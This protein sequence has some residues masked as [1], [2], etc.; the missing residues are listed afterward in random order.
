MLSLTRKCFLSLTCQILMLY[1]LFQ[2]LPYFLL[3]TLWMLQ[4]PRPCLLTMVQVS[5]AAAVWKCSLRHQYP[6][7]SITRGFICM[8]QPRA[9]AN[10]ATLLLLHMVARRPLPRASLQL[11]RSSVHAV[12]HAALLL[13]HMVAKPPLPRA[14]LQL[15]H[16]ARLQLPVARR[17]T[18]ARLQRMSLLPQLARP[19]RRYLH[20]CLIR[21][22]HASVGNP[23]RKV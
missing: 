17:R 5:N 21:V 11:S 8:A 19:C 15:S 4:M 22:Q 9:V 3:T 13:L 12:S 10:H 16:S 6:A 14:S 23:K 2:S 20:G 1:R 7:M 18:H